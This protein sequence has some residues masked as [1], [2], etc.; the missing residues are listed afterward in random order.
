MNPFK[1]IALGVVHGIATT[2]QKHAQP[3]DVVE[4]F[5][6]VLGWVVHER[7]GAT[8]II[9]ITD[10]GGVDRAL[11]VWPAGDG[12]YIFLVTSR[13]NFPTL[14]PS[15]AEYLLSRNTYLNAGAWM[16]ESIAGAMTL[17]LIHKAHLEGLNAAEF[18]N[19]CAAMIREAHDFDG[20][21][22]TA[23]LLQ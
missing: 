21:L 4:R 12:L 16:S 20:K 14:P 19:I 1:E 22:R 2:L 15:V 10:P 11:S 17:A 6:G 5:C 3:A 8:S 9:N 18:H 13:A 23:G 7:Q